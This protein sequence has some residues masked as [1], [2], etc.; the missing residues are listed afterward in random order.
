MDRSLWRLLNFQ[1]IQFK[2]I[3]PE[4][5]Y[6]GPVSPYLANIAHLEAYVKANNVDLW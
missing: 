6:Y 3:G 4:V 1:G 5:D 2:A